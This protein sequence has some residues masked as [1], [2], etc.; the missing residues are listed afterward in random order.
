MPH[1]NPAR[2]SR[3]AHLFLAN[4]LPL[5]FVGMTSVQKSQ[6]AQHCSVVTIK[7]FLKMGESFQQ[8]IGNDLMFSVRADT[9]RERP[10]GWTFSI[11]NADGHDFIAPVNP[12]LRFNPSQNLGAGY[13]LTA[14]DSLKHN[15]ELHFLINDS[16]YELLAPLWRDAL[17][18]Y[19][20][21]EP[22]KAA[23]SYTSALL[24]IPLGILRLR[25][26]QADI[27]PDDR[28]LSA[29]FEAELIAPAQLQFDPSLLPRQGPCPAPL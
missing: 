17:W 24:R 19:S 26:L 4:V 3:V 7:F 16:D 5:L 8:K 13:G 1:F 6:N 22:D 12:P 14:K 10:D 27:S 18:P 2:T 23:D 25:V 11:D 29:I 21:P 15:R 28:I 20:A 9:S